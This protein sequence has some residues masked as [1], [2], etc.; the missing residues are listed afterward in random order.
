M[1]FVLEGEVPVGGMGV[2][3]TTAEEDGDGGGGSG[4]KRWEALGTRTYIASPWT[5]PPKLPDPGGVHQATLACRHIKHHLRPFPFKDSSHNYIN[6]AL[7]PPF[8]KVSSSFALQ[9]LSMFQ[10]FAEWRWIGP[11]Q[12][13]G[14]S[15]TPYTRDP[16]RPLD[17]RAHGR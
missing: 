6:T 16:A 9:A 4:S 1:V 12:R 10:A 2:G 5:L 17:V 14:S 15:W 13:P 8:D 3:R 7:K 11:S